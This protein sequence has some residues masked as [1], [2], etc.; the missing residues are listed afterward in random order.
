MVKI[1]VLGSFNLD[2][3]MRAERRPA[4]GETLPGEFAMFLGG[5]GFNQA[6]AA[7]RLGAEVAVAGRV[8]ADEFGRQFLEALDREGIARDAVS[9]DAAQGTGVASIVIE[10]DGENAIL[11][12]PRANRG[13]TAA[14]IGR[15]TRLFDG[16]S[17][18]MLQLET[19][20]E[21]ALEFAR[22]ARVRGAR[23]LLNPAPATVVPEE[24]LR[25]SDVL[26][27][28]ALEARA[29]TGM[30]GDG[31]EAA[32]AM[33]EGLRGRGPAAVVVTLGGLGAVAVADGVRC[34]VPAFKVRV[35]D[36]V[37]AG[38][39]FCAALAVG[40]AEGA[41]MEA[42]V[43]FGC[44]AGALAATRAGAE[45]SMPRRAEADALAAREVPA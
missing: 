24:M 39:A 19:S 41:E 30:A 33:A 5:K 32:I 31:I 2:L 16:A 36:T 44:A 1:A 23:T 18:A 8:G 21:G 37:G 13:V 28:N 25:L 14:S 17:V 3:V 29:L 40:L 38:D 15:E 10:P 11:Q 7:R 20:M 34:H 12:A 26:V 42:A 9:V 4:P 22:Q 43:R 45:P 35:T 6:I 27:P